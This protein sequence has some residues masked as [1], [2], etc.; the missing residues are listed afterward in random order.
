MPSPPPHLSPARVAAV[1]LLGL[2]VAQSALPPRG[3]R[4]PVLQLGEPLRSPPPA[5]PRLEPAFQAEMTP[6]DVARGL[7]HL[8]EHPE[9]SIA[10]TDAQRAILGPKVQA[11]RA[12][13]AEVDALRDEQRRA[14]RAP[15]LAGEALLQAAVGAR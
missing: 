9:P 11:A 13:R 14:R 7:L 10:L 8:A 6:D 12:A 1:G 2:V 3:Q 4:A 5:D 15:G